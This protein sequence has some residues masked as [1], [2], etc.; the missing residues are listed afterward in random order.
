[1][2][3][4]PHAFRPASAQSQFHTAEPSTVL[5]Q[6]ASE[7]IASWC[8]RRF[9]QILS[10]LFWLCACIGA[11]ASHSRARSNTVGSNPLLAAV[12]RA[13][14]CTQQFCLVQI[15][16]ALLT[17]DK[18]ASTLKFDWVWLCCTAGLPWLCQLT[19]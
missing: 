9:W 10:C 3:G 14:V 1:M 4:E 17:C 12:A 5:L 8:I 2:Q 16:P 15:M 19:G 7:T 18:I 6:S 11:V 13:A